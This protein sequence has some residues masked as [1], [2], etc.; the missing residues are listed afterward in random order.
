MRPNNS[1]DRV[2]R[3][4]A[5]R[6]KLRPFTVLAGAAAALAWTGSSAI[7]Q[8]ALPASS[9]VTPTQFNP[10]AG[11]V[12]ASLNAP[13][14]GASFTGSLRSAVVQNGSTLDFYYQ[15]VNDATSQTSI[16]RETNFNF[17][18]FN[19]SVFFRSDNAG[20]AGGFV[21]GTETP[22]TADRDAG[23]VV[24][25][26]F[27][28]GTGASSGKINPGETSSILVIRT[29]ASLFAPGISS[30]INGGAASVATFMPVIPEPAAL[31]LLGGAATLA[32]LRR[33]RP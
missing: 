10:A 25:F 7:A 15:V 32:T 29:D 1:S 14:T 17:N 21:A 16:G 33:R 18:G 22:D 31:G 20:G 2:A 19:T 8:V 23:G 9:Q 5:V 11:A 28:Q 30:V 13:F 12:V 3:P 24:A 27:L 6:G 4:L 26:N